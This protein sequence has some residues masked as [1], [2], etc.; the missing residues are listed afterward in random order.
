MRQKYLTLAFTAIALCMSSCSKSIDEITEPTEKKAVEIFTRTAPTVYIEY[1]V[2]LY[3]FKSTGEL[4][5]NV[6]AEEEGDPL[7]LQLPI[8]SYKFTAI[9]GADGLSPVTSPTLNTGIGIPED[10]R[11]TSPIQMGHADLSIGAT[12]T[13]VTITMTY[14]VAKVDVELYNIPTDATEVSVTLSTQ[15][16]DKTFSGAWSGE[17]TV[18]IPLTQ[19][20]GT[21]TWK[22][23]TVYTLPG[24]ENQP[25][26]VGISVT[27][28]DQTKVYSYTHTT[29]LK[30][31]TPYT[32]K[33]SYDGEVNINGTIAAEGWNN[34]VEISFSFGSENINN[35]GNDNNGNNGGTNAGDVYNVE[36]FPTK[37]EI[38]NGHFIAEVNEKGDNTAQ[39]LLL[40]LYEWGHEED[41]RNVVSEEKF[42]SYIEGD[43]KKWRIPT[44][45]ELIRLFPDYSTGDGI[46]AANLAL[47][48]QGKGT[49]LTMN[50]RY[51]C[52]NG[53]TIESVQLKSK[54]EAIGLTDTE[55][56]YLRLVKTVTVSIQ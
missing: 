42:T 9:A 26:T 25:L 46:N 27:A 1:P 28:G 12:N 45:E 44:S 22:S 4:V 50:Y 41:A 20:E 21:T 3:A 52:K 29:N 31:G 36:K 55:V 5:E 18:T 17:N 24:V 54:P 47:V 35:G 10:G 13:E 34:P 2:T 16:A 32:L 15:Y 19:T 37:G 30:A 11:I 33:G 14:Q 56:Y 49:K 23:T 8:G 53:E 39:L 38:W 51:L 43:I 48:N 6:T 40:S 7:K